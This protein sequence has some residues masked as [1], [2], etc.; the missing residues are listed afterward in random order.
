MKIDVRAPSDAC[1]ARYG[2]HVTSTYQPA[3][4]YW[5]FQWIETGIFVGITALLVAGAVVLVLR[6]DA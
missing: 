5:T 3:G 2:F 1:M 4:R 6:R